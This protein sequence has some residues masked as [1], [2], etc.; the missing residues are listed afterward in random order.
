MYI[1]DAD[2]GPKEI[3]ISF[4]DRSISRASFDWGK[5][6]EAFHFYTYNP[7]G[8]LVLAASEGFAPGLARGSI[9]VEFSETVQPLRFTNSCE[10][11]IAIDDL[12]V[13]PTP[14]PGTML[15]LGSG[16]LGLAGFGRKKLSKK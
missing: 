16:L 9:S 4:N 5:A 7:H 1:V 12:D 14:E 2:L 6:L 10:G 15:L 3:E 11:C 13:S 8:D